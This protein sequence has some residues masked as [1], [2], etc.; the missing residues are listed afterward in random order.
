MFFD[1]DKYSMSADTNDESKW[2][3]KSAHIVGKPLT[4]KGLVPHADHQ[5]GTHRIS[6]AHFEDILPQAS[7][8]CI[9]F[10]SDKGMN[11]ANEL[12]YATRAAH[13]RA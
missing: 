9:S 10:G 6:W 3:E 7:S 5:T 13:M 8:D 2:A 4:P 12:K 1:S 11:K